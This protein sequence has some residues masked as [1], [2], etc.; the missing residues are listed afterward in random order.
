MIGAKPL[1]L[2]GNPT[3]ELKDKEESIS[4][5]SSYYLDSV[6]GKTIFIK[7]RLVVNL[8][9]LKIMETTGG[10]VFIFRANLHY[11]SLI[12]FT[13]YSLKKFHCIFKLCS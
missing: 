6:S 8:N 12:L 3:I 11:S 7:L 5:N 9:Y 4:L 13:K 10:I 1:W 2:R